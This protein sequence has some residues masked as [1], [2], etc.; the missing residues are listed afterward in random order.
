MIFTRNSSLPILVAII[1]G[2]SH[3]ASCGA[4]SN[5]KKTTVPNRTQNF[6]QNALPTGNG[7]QMQLVNPQ[8]QQRLD[9][10][11]KCA[12]GDTFSILVNIEGANQQAFSLGYMNQS[13]IQLQISGNNVTFMNVPKGIHT[14]TFVARKSE[15]CMKLG[16]QNCQPNGQQV[17]SENSYDL[18]KKVFLSSVDPQEEFGRIQSSGG[19]LAGVMGRGEGFLGSLLNSFTGGGGGGLFGQPQQGQ[20][21]PQG[22]PPQGGPAPQQGF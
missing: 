18:S 14:V 6:G 8:N 13:G 12:M 15:D 19:G 7:I 17:Q 11:L 2:M 4:K 5:R 10:S 1:V 9:A 21:M 20:P 3:L 22:Y 16:R